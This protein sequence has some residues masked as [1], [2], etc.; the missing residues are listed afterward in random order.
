MNAVAALAGGTRPLAIPGCSV[1]RHAVHRDDRGWFA[2]PF[3][4]A[5]FASAGLSHAWAECFASLSHRGVVRGFHLQLPPSDHDKLVWVAAGASM[6]AVLDLRV[7]SPSFGKIDVA[8]LDTV[9][10]EALYVPRGVAHAFQAL[11]DVTVLVYLVTSAHDPAH[12]AGIRWDSAHVK[13]PLPP[14]AISSRDRGLPALEA[15][16]SPFR[17]GA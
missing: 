17:F 10:G 11:A 15:F 5:R 2:K 4:A 12:D 16:D 14:A 8:E 7:G 9:Q 3:D 1:L 13:W 6:S